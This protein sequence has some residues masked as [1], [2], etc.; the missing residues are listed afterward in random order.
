M[1]TGPV[2]NPTGANAAS[3]DPRLRRLERLTSLLDDR[4]VIPGTGVRFGL[5]A[6]IGLVPGVGDMLSALI[7]L[8]FIAEAARI[9]APGPVLLRMTAN[10]VVDLL[11][12]SVPILGDVFDT[13]WRANRRNIELL[14][15]HL[16][17]STK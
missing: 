5:D 15:E 2:S 17:R 14:R 16:S 3:D 6:V 9:G 8:H 12:G 10:V 13:R 4:L 1:K 11:V 7:S